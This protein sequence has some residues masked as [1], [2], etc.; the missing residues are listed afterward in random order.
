MQVIFP[1]GYSLGGRK[2]GIEVSLKAKA[3]LRDEIEVLFH[4]SIGHGRIGP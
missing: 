1:V 4:S 2:L 3:A